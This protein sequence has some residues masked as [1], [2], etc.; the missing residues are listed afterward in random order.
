MLSAKTVAQKPLGSV[1]P[2][3][4]PAQVEAAAVV[5]AGLRVV[6]VAAVF[7]SVEQAAATRSRNTADRENRIVEGWLGLTKYGEFNHLPL[8]RDAVHSHSQ[9]YRGP[10]SHP[11]FSTDASKISDPRC[12][13]GCRLRIR[14]Q[15]IE[16]RR[17]GIGALELHRHDR[18]VTGGDDGG[19]GH[20]HDDAP[21]AHQ[22][23]VRGLDGGACPGNTG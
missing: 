22:G 8:A 13:S 2:P 1:R 17:I 19:P 12:D 16:R 21:S 7:F 23:S 5:E 10:S 9:C 6:S 4:S 20:R 3:L 11:R 14:Q 15:I 18:D